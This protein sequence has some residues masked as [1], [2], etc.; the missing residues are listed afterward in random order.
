MITIHEL[1]RERGPMC[2]KCG[3]R[4]A[5]ERHH[6]LIHDVK[7]F[8][9]QLTCKENIMQACDVCH[10]GECVLN[11]YDMRV[12][13]WGVQCERYGKKYMK[14]WITKLLADCPK[15]EYSRRIDFVNG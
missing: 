9:E 8:H 6:A 5:V 12:W 1:R 10:R 4:E 15:L 3:I 11:G 2:E 13:F 14:R 7:R